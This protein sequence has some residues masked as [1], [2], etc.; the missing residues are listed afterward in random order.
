MLETKKMNEM[1]GI[2][3]PISIFLYEITKTFFKLLFSKV[4]P[5]KI[6]YIFADA[7][8]ICIGKQKKWTVK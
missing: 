8:R 7:Y 2:K 3:P 6:V 5:K 1:L 4:L